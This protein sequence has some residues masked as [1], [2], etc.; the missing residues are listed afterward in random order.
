[1]SS[2]SNTTLRRPSE[3]HRGQNGFSESF[4]PADKDH[5]GD[6]TLR[7]VRYAQWMLEH[8]G[9][10]LPRLRELGTKK[11]LPPDTLDYVDDQIKQLKRQ[12]A[13]DLESLC[14]F[15]ASELR[16]KMLDHRRCIDDSAYM[17]IDESYSDQVEF[18]EALRQLD[19]R[20]RDDPDTRLALEDALSKL[21]YTYLRS[22]LPLIRRRRALRDRDVK[23]RKQRDAWFPQSIEEYRDITERDVQLRMARFLVADGTEQERMMDKFGWAYRRVDPLRAAYKSNAEFRTEIQDTLKDIQASDPRKRVVIKHPIF[24]Q[25]LPYA[26][27]SPLS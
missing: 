12:H 25:A 20:M 24:D 23:I 26:T 18:R 8:K 1:M 10:P 3:A 6:I 16:Q 27:F 19:Q 2:S 7:N 22:L 21:R 11:P 13:R 15:Q 5:P 4:E 9:V 14:A 17:D